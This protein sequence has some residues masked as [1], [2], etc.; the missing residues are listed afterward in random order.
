MPPPRRRSRAGWL[1]AAGILSL[2]LIAAAGYAAWWYMATGKVRSAALKWVAGQQA[3]GWHITHGSTSRAGFPLELGV[4]FADPA[5]EPMGGGASWRA[6]EAL[7]S[8]P[9]I[10]PRSLRLAIAGE[11]RFRFGAGAGALDATGRAEMFAFDLVPAASWLPNGTLRVSRMSFD[12]EG[13]PAAGIDSLELVSTGDPAAASGPEASGYAA[14]L[15]A[16]GIRLPP[17]LATP[18]GSEISRLLLE[19]KI[20]GALQPRPWPAALARWRDQGGVIEVTRVVVEGGSVVIDG[21]GTLALDG[22][23][24][25]V[26]AMSARIQGYEAALD[27]L[28]AEK[29]IPPHIAATARILLRGLAR[30]GADNGTTLTAPLTLQDRALT[31]GPVEILRLPEVR[32]LDGP[33]AR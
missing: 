1:I 28:A 24:Q 7:L 31:I 2:L 27:R 4:R 26:G 11:Q 23:G 25:P 20:Q 3:Q 12:T 22:A 9:V 21:D 14:R 33:T 15:T 18:M 32:W 30:G 19:A 5:A 16:Q 10:G 6:E 8:T 29:A 13:N 17:S